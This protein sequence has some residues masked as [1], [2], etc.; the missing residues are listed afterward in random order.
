MTDEFGF[1][2]VSYAS[3]SPSIDA[4]NL[5]TTRGM[6]ELCPSLGPSAVMLAAYMFMVGTPKYHIN[7]L[8]DAIGSGGKPSNVERIIKRLIRFGVL[9]DLNDGCYV[10]N[11]NVV[12]RTPQ[13]S[14][15]PRVSA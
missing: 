1:I 15:P 12:P 8:A 10:L 11:S 9:E 5:C 2:Y 4:A 3:G 6:F 13:Y 7:E 14:R